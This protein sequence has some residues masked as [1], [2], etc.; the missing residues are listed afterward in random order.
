MHLSKLNYLWAAQVSIYHWVTHS[1]P[2]TL[3]YKQKISV[4]PETWQN[5][6]KHVY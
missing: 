1:M 6:R 5:L 2:I 4:K 3:Q